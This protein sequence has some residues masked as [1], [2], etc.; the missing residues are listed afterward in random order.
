MLIII[1]PI[2]FSYFVVGLVIL[3][4]KKPRETQ[5][6]MDGWM[7]R[8]LFI[9]CLTSAT[10]REAKQITIFKLEVNDFVLL[11]FYLLL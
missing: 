11:S 4:K 8:P 1:N 2:I 5:R 6:P 7:D 10:I 9:L 3:V